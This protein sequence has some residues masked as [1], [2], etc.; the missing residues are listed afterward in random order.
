MRLPLIF[1]LVAILPVVAAAGEVVQIDGLPHVRNQGHA[2]QGVQTV[3][4]QEQ[5]R[6]GGVDDE[7]LFGFVNA[8]ITGP[9][10]NVLVLDT[11][12]SAVQV[13]SPDGRHLQTMGREGDGPGEFRRAQN[14]MNL[15]G[16]RTGVICQMLGQIVAFER[17][18]NPASS[19]TPGD[20]TSG[21][22][23]VIWDAQCRG[24]FLYLSGQRISPG[25][26]GM[27][28][29]DYLARF[30]LTG[31]EQEPLLTKEGELDFNRAVF[32]ERDMYFVNGRWALGPDGRVYAP[33]H[34][35]RYLINDYAPDGTLERVIEREFQ[36]RQRTQAENDR[37][38]EGLL[39]VVNGERVQMEREVEESDPCIAGMFVDDEGNLWVQ[40][41][42]SRHIGEGIVC[43]YDVFDPEGHLVKQVNLTGQ[44]HPLDDGFFPLRDGRYVV[45]EGLSAA[46]RGM[47]AGI[48]E[49]DAEEA[50]ELEEEDLELVCYGTG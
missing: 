31:A 7:I 10:G 8:V 30:D 46:R 38:G 24:D 42:N 1:T 13:Y 16:G 33:P 47:L 4:L 29:T 28:T 44:V 45:A 23:G 50:D 32:V 9:D 41:A 49:S 35:D 15:P 21:R 25:Q 14:L 26:E 19:V 43:Q 48:N 18:G 11:Q 27:K 36:P 22:M 5:W 12:L 17:D 20:P 3:P 34:R 2:A 40:H 37:I 6:V 39:I